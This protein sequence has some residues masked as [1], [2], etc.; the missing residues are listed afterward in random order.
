[1]EEI[2]ISLSTHSSK[3]IEDLEID[4]FDYIVTLCDEAKEI[5]PYVQSKWVSF[6]HRSFADPTSWWIIDFQQVSM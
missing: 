5:C 6:L 2:G 4:D 3:H 1:M